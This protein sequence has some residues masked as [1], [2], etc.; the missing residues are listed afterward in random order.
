MNYFRGVQITVA[1]ALGIALLVGA[2]PASASVAEGA[3]EEIVITASRRPQRVLD[4]AATVSVINT[5]ELD[6]AIAPTLAETLRDV[7]GVQVSDAG[8]PGISHI[9]IR[10][11]ESRRTAILVNSQ[12]ITDH[13]D[14]GAPLSLHPAMIERIEV[15]RGSGSVLYG[16]RALSGVV[17]FITRKGGT[18][19]LEATVASSYDSATEGYSHFASVFGD[20]RGFEYRVAGVDSDYG[21]RDTPEGSVDNTAYDNSGVYLFGGKQ[22]GAHRLEYTYEDYQASSH[23]Y[24]EE[25]VRTAYPL[26]DFYIETP[27]RDRAKHGLFY[28]WNLDNHWARNIEANAFH[29]DS[30]REFYTRTE[31][32]SYH[33]EVTNTDELTTDGALLQLNL[34]PLGRHTPL[35]GVQYLHDEV[36]Q[37]RL[38]D[39]ESSAPPLPSGSETINDQ[40]GIETWALFALDEWA[41]TELLTLTAGM[42]QYYVD[43]SLDASSRASLHPGNLDDDSKL[44]GTL[45]LVWDVADDLRLRAN[46]AQGYV[47]P[48]LAQLAT[49]AYA[50]SSFVN[51]D[52]GLNPE[53]SIDYETGIRMERNDIVLDATAFYMQSDDY[54]HHQP[55]APGECPGPRDR[56][57]LNIGESR[58]H[59]VELYLAWLDGPAGVQPYANLTWMKR[60]NR[61]ATFSTWDSGV[62][63]LAGRLGLRWDGALARIPTVWLDA[64]L[65][66]ESRSELEEPGTARGALGLEERSSWVT[67]NLSTGVALGS[68]DQYQLGLDLLNLTDKRYLA[69]GE[70]V[71][72]AGRGAAL[73]LSVSW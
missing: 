8:Q 57:Y 39:T 42:R 59:G 55:C 24:V 49:G 41:L 52:P 61:F 12:E 66:G 4:S 36:D 53:T 34:Q 58:A 70:N 2:V 10:G 51:P 60:Q 46:V 40:A 9:R 11:E 28:Q 56:R 62:P 6:R 73:K 25:E 15:V 71:Y 26:T 21:D 32:A 18:R 30:H 17:N 48:S 72:G 68:N 47:Y 1:G 37:D 16:S 35:A 50:G 67:A 27:R 20:L 13:H 19:E 43:G 31:T 29:Q 65:R 33:R 23:V 63:D 64:F 14:Y 22:L 7:A 69:S 45:G 38:V 44:I 5:L 54:I 3:L